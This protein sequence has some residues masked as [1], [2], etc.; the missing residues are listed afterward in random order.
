MNKTIKCPICG[1]DMIKYIYDYN[2]DSKEKT[3]YKCPECGHKKTII[4]Y[5]E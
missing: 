4:N 2:T 1:S 5:N 3:D